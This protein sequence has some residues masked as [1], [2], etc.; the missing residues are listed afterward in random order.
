M[1]K[2]FFFCLLFIF[3]FEGFAQPV[4]KDVLKA[5]RDKLLHHLVNKTI[6]KNL[7]LPLSDS[8]EENWQDAFYALE[9]INYHSVFVA[10]KIS[11]AIDHIQSRSISFQKSLLE[12]INANYKDTFY[13]QTKHFLQKTINTK[14]FVMCAAYLLNSSKANAEKKILLNNIN[15]KLS[16]DPQNPLLQ[17]LLYQVNNIGTTLTTP[18]IHSLLEKNYLPG[19]VLMISFQRKN[20]NYPGLVIIRN[21]EGNFIKDKNGELFSV[22]QL[23]RSLSNTPGYISNG[24]TPE[25]IFRMDG[26]DTSKISSIGPTTNIQLTMPFENTS[27]H[28]YKESI[29]DTSWDI[30]AY[31][32]LLPNNFQNYYPAYQTYYAGKAGRTEIIAHGTTVNPLYYKGR[33]FY[34]LT[35]TEGCLCTK[36]IW[37][38]ANGMRLESD[39]QKLANAITTAGGPDG[40][41]IVINIDDQQ[42]A[43]TLNDIIPFLKSAGQK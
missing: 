14:I 17:Q 16:G 32:K 19:N 26:F 15:Q 20:R 28:F 4:C 29:L 38:E 5:N 27:A 6:T 11:F 41:C 23:A 2:T 22:S 10:K 9:L 25:G 18:S 33:P 39:Q 1:K 42:K 24:N 13:K 30:N 21:K 36:E 35:P 43:V 34:P 31:K 8:T 12:L 37:S 40:Y 3:S 7:S